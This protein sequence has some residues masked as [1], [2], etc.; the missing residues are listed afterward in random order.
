MLA[1]GTT[2]G[3]FFTDRPKVKN[4]TKRDTLV[5]QVGS[6]GGGSALYHL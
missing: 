2:D 3:A 4:L 6:L 5:L 1:N